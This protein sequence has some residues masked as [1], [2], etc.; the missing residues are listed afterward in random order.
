V[1]G[2]PIEGFGKTTG[3]YR[4]ALDTLFAAGITARRV[5]SCQSQ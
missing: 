1:P 3:V 2:L 4:D 5:P